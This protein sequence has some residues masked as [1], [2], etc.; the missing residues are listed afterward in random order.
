M[1]GSGKPVKINATNSAP[2]KSASKKRRVVSSASIVDEGT[3]SSSD[4]APAEPIQPETQPAA[5]GGEGTEETKPKVVLDVSALLEKL[6]AEVATHLAG[7]KSIAALIRETAK[8]HGKELRAKGSR[9]RKS[10]EAEAGVVVEP[11]PEKTFEIQEPLREFLGTQPG[12]KVGKRA[13]RKTL[14]LYIKEHKLQDPDDHTLIKPDEKLAKLFGPPRFVTTKQN[15]GY[16]N[17]NA[18]RYIAE[19]FI[20]PEPAAPTPAPEIAPV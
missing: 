6:K 15:H 8:A 20:V 12:E 17:L 4:S 1:V 3:P 18:L 11:K 14:S 10:P 13:A 5:D 19:Y 9:K 16:S 7:L 2:V